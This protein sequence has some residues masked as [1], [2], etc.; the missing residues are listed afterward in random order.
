MKPPAQAA[1]LRVHLSLRF[2]SSTQRPHAQHRVLPAGS[3]E[4]LKG[5]E[6]LHFYL[7]AR[8][9]SATSPTASPGRMAA[10]QQ[11]EGMRMPCTQHCAAIPDTKACSVLWLLLP[12]A[13]SPK[14]SAGGAAC[15]ECTV[16]QRLRGMA[17]AHPVAEV[18]IVI[19]ANRSVW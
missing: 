17:G 2:A 8:P 12:L 10:K 9:H 4:D 5:W 19:G 3:I 6:Y 15:R 7:H 1:D 13:I 18:P 16:A 14:Q 11:I